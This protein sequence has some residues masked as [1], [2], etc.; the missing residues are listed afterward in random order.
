MFGERYPNNKETMDK[1]NEIVSE[2][3]KIKLILKTYGLRLDKLDK[4]NPN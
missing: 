3:N 1:I 4:S 2:F